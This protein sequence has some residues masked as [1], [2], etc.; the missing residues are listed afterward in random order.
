VVATTNLA[1]LGKACNNIGTNLNTIRRNRR[2]G[3][4]RSSSSSLTVVDSKP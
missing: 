1:T 4:R 3:S 2:N